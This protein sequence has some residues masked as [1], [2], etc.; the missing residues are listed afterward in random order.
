MDTYAIQSD[1]LLYQSLC[2]S[3]EQ[4]NNTTLQPTSFI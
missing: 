3:E 2:I 1:L 4:D